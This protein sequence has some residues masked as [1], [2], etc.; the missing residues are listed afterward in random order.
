MIWSLYRAVRAVI[1]LGWLCVTALLVWLLLV[2]PTIPPQG[3]AKDYSVELPEG[4]DIE[5]LSIRLT[6][7]E[8]VDRPRAWVLYMRLIGAHGKLR[9]GW[10]VLNRSLSAHDLLPRLSRGYGRAEV[11]VVL[12]EG[13]TRFD[14]AVRLARFGIAPEADFLAASEDQALLRSLGIEQETAEGYLFPATYT[15]RQESSAERVVRRLVRVF[16]SRTDALF[17]AY[18]AETDESPSALTPAQL[19]T[20]ASIVEREAVAADERPIIAGV[21]LNRLTDPSFRPRRLQADPTVAYG[22]LV[23]RD[24][25]PSCRDFDG[26]RVTPEMVRDPENPYSTY[27]I[28]G[29]PPGP[30]S[31]PGMASLEAAVHPASHDLFY[32]VAV[33]GGRHAFSHSL[34]EHNR[35]IH[36][37]DR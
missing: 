8:I 3:P 34:A 6:Q 29:L 35:L 22:C 9:S 33:G 1:L 26:R 37:S 5:T 30:I 31:N 16:R 7:E 12:P 18:A 2:F 17:A 25:V 19:V 13:Y 32:F 15:F 14:M 21:F 4:T 11:S 10:I 20:L 36:G 28:E 23:A 24:K 27:R